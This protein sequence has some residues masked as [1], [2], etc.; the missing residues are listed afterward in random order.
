MAA[1]WMLEPSLTASIALSIDLLVHFFPFVLLLEQS[2]IAGA[3]YERL[4]GLP[5]HLLFPESMVHY[6]KQKVSIN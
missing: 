3:E 4:R 5:W 2:S 6:R 1:R